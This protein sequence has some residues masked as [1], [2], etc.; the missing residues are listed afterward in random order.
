MHSFATKT[1]RHRRL[2]G[3]GLIAVATLAGSTKLHA[4]LSASG[5]GQPAQ[6]IPQQQA[7]QAPVII[8]SGAASSAAS[9]EKAD[10][11]IQLNE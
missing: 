7:A 9:S 8:N 10:Y 4:Q 1:V 5:Y 11:T 2:L 6:P 3:A